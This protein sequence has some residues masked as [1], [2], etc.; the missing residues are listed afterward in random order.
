MS[1]KLNIKEWSEADRPREKLLIRGKSELSSA[2]LIAIL[3]GSGS[4]EES[5][6]DLSK[7]ILSSV[8]HDLHELA[9]LSITDFMNFKGVGEAKAVSIIAALELGR[10][11]KRAPLT[12]KNQVT[13]SRDAFELMEEHLGDLDHEE[14]WILLLNRAN[15]LIEI[16]NVSKGGVSGTV[17][18]AK[19]IF[20]AALSKLASS[21]IVFHN[22]PSGNLKP[23]KADLLLTKKLVEGG[24][25]L[26]IAVLDHLILGNNSYF[27]FA[28]EGMI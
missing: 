20:K 2:E 28:D 8:N 6:V 4:R 15:R 27:S 9:S 7:R 5:A 13:S 10:R 14:F 26:D 24:K 25:N 17:A 23:S 1:I 21:I 11:K 19:L 3:I 12:K 16:R 22:H 18:D